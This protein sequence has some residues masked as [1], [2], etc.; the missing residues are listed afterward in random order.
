MATRTHPARA[1]VAPLCWI[2]VLLDGFDMV[3]LGTV[4]PVLLR[5]DIWGM[6][7]GMG[8]AIST[9]GLV[10][11][12]IGALTIGAITDVIGR[13]KAMIIA[14]TSFSV[15][16]ALCALAPSA[17]IFGLLRFLAGIGLGG[18]MPTAITLVGEYA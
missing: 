5:E 15:F 12:T 6:T 2:A 16:T 13:R 9:A 1:W 3:V 4:L 11:M 17:M 8:S 10:G 7:P 14:V 18:C